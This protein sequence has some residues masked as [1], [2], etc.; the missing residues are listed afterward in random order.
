VPCIQGPGQVARGCARPL[1]KAAHSVQASSTRSC[2]RCCKCTLARRFAFTLNS[3][4]TL[5]V[6][7]HG[8]TTPLAMRKVRVHGTIQDFASDSNRILQ[9]LEGLHW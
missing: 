6:L 7:S 3:L 8:A 2:I 9:C 5:R 4:G 1:N